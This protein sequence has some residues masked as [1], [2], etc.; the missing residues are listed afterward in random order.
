MIQS[1][2]T[3]PPPLPPKIANNIGGDCRGLSY[4]LRIE[5]LIY[6]HWE[7]TSSSERVIS[8]NQVCVLGNSGEMRGEGRSRPTG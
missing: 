4:S 5:P 2:H 3:P 1:N 7:T 6:G 8:H